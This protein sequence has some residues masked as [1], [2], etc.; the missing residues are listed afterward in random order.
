V[1][2]D[3]RRNGLHEGKEGNFGVFRSL[4][5][6]MTVCATSKF[7]SRVICAVTHRGRGLVGG[8]QGGYLG[9]FLREFETERSRRSRNN[10]C[11]N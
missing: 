5:T 4:D 10:N 1:H 7:S 6:T 9:A 8:N 11:C 2:S 3:S